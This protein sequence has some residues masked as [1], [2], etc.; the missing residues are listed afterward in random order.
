M[1][2]KKILLVDDSATTLMMEQKVLRAGPYDIVTAKTASE[3]VD[4][5]ATEQ[6]DLIVLDTVMPD[7]DGLEACRRIREHAATKTTPIIIV[8]QRFEV[9][10]GEAVRDSGCSDTIGKPINGAELLMKVHGLLAD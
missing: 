4:R 1:N 7:M 10:T 6:P 2:R 8:T 9:L 3:A 5:A